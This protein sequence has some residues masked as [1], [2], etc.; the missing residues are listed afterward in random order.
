MRLLAPAAI[1]V[2]LLASIA[3]AQTL[4]RIEQNKALNIGFRS[5]AAPLSFVNDEGHPAGYAPNLCAAVAQGIANRLKMTELN[6]N[7]VEVDT[8]NRFD[9]VAA[10]EV[11]ILCGAATITLS[12]RDT[13]DF[14]VP[15]YVDGTGVL[16]PQ[17][18]ASGFADLAGRT[19]GVR[20]DTTTETA[21]TNSLEAA[22]IE[23]RTE[24]FTSHKAG[25]DALRNREIDAYFADQSILLHEFVTRDMASG[26]VLSPEILTVEKQGL[27]L[28][29]GDSDFRLMVDTILA[30]LFQSGEVER[31]FAATL[32]GVEPGVALK[33]M[34]LTSPTLP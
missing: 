9:K 3:S 11:D 23:A 33:A 30:E 13:V 12:R 28:A 4:E 18:G 1:A 26:Y 29:R 25:F 20:S 34:F 2:T 10:G 7:F 21:L 17:G 32:P 24:R 22:G 19:V 8:Q 14:S 6:V 16:L 31:I 27:A 15:T 5:D